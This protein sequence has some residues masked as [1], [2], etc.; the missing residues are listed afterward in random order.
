MTTYQ[1]STD[2]ISALTKEQYRV[3]QESRTEQAGS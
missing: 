2:A 1:K 3:T